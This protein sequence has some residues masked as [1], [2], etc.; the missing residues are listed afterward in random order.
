MVSGIVIEGRVQRSRRRAGPQFTQPILIAMILLADCSARGSTEQC[1]AGLP[2]SATNVTPVSRTPLGER[3]GIQVQSW[4]LQP[5]DLDRI[6]AAGFGT[7]RWGMPWETIERTPG[8]YDWREADRFIKALAGSHLRSVVILGYGNPLYAGPDGTT[9]DATAGARVEPR[10]PS[11]TK[12][13]EAF[14]RFAAAAA[15]RYRNQP[16]SWEIWNEPDSPTFWQPKPDPAS[17]AALA[18]AACTA[19]RASAPRSTIIGGVGAAMPNAVAAQANIYQALMQAGAFRCIDG[20]SSHAYRM[21]RFYR[22]PDPESLEQDILASRHYLSAELGSPQRQRFLITEW[23][24]ST[25]VVSA[26]LQAAYLVRANLANAATGVPLTIW[27]E[28]RDSRADVDDPESHFGLL[29]TTGLQKNDRNALGVMAELAKSTIIARLPSDCADARAF[30]VRKGGAAFL[31]DDER[32]RAHFYVD[33]V[34]QGDVSFMPAIFRVA[35]R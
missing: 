30:L 15:A 3:L 21:S 6:A 29:T 10:A 33:G 24:F 9:V 27:Y 13:R 31:A 11:A 8:I 1:H 34:R 19:M 25:G 5:G 17:Y 28:W 20:I 23:G 14:A 26:N 12:A 22:Q 16:V 32:R 7:V 4:Y 35:R 2:R 18:M